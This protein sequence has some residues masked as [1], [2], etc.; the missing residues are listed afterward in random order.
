[1]AEGGSGDSGSPGSLRP[2]LPGARGV[3]GRR[4]AGPPLTPGRLPSI[5]SRDLTLGGVKKV[6]TWRWDPPNQPFGGDPASCPIALGPLAQVG[7]EE[8]QPEG[9]LGCSLSAS[10][11]PAAGLV[12]VVLSPLVQRLV[13]PLSFAENLHPQHN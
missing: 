12:S 3:L 11:S 2:A 5:R 8:Q 13:P 9:I 1:M 6:S 4:P 10:S 7:C